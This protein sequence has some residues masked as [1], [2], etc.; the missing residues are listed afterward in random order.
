MNN[1]F[2]C[3]LRI[4]V[5]QCSKISLSCGLF[6][7][8]SFPKSRSFPSWLIS[9]FL[10]EER[11]LSFFNILHVTLADSVNKLTTVYIS[12]RL[13]MR[14]PH[15]CAQHNTLCACVS[16]HLIIHSQLA[17]FSSPAL[18]AVHSNSVLFGS[19]SCVTS[20]AVG[21]TV[22]PKVR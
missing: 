11:R 21:Q 4:C 18:L 5:L 13:G 15:Q 12:G 1:R 8:K 2:G 22:E 7:R 20:A 14:W 9:L 6:F 17:H 16:T 3:C 19:L 10:A